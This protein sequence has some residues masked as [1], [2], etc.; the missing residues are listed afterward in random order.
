[1]TWLCGTFWR[2]WETAAALGS[3]LGIW[4]GGEEKLSDY[5]SGGRMRFTERSWQPA[6]QRQ[7]SKSM[8][9]ALEGNFPWIQKDSTVCNQE[10]C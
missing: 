3:M 6:V 2:E 10:N 8:T 9:Q 5:K 7:R 4:A 1:M